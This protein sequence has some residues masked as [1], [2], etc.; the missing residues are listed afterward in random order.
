MRASRIIC[1]L[2]ALAA[3]AGCASPGSQYQQRDVIQEPIAQDDPYNGAYINA[4]GNIVYPGHPDCSQGNIDPRISRW[5]ARVG[6]PRAQTRQ[7][8]TDI[9]PQQRRSLAPQIIRLTC[10][11]NLAAGVQWGAQQPD[12]SILVCPNP[13]SVKPAESSESAVTCTYTGYI[14]PLT[15]R[16]P[17]TGICTSTFTYLFR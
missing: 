3:V 9:Q 12:G 10:E 6:N 4:Q 13:E 17:F 5:C 16:A 11:Q 15:G 7:Q 2:F 8:N 1:S 14:D